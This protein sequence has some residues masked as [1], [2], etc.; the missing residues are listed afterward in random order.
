MVHTQHQVEPA[1]LVAA[2]DVM[3]EPVVQVLR[4]KA[5]RAGV[6]A[7]EAVV[8]VKPVTLTGQV[9]EEMVVNLVF[10]V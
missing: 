2:P 3:V 1:A 7:V 4:D 6:V 8:Q 10:Q 9:E 5:M